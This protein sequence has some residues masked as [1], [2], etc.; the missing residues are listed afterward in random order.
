M[1]EEQMIFLAD[2]IDRALTGDEEERAKC[3]EEV[4][5]LLKQFP[6]YN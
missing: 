2:I 5:A 1:K 3:R 6:L 4:D